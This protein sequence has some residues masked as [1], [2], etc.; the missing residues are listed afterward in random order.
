M[1]SLQDI[2]GRIR[3]IDST[4]KITSAMNLVATSKLN[5]SKEAALRTRPF[6]NKILSTMQSIGA[7][8]KGQ[9]SPFLKGGE[10]SCCCCTFGICDR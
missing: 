8:A 2:K 4:K 9:G 5:K 1:A 10:S 3:S 6:F 7:N